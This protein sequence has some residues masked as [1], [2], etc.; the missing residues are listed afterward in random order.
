MV[1]VGDGDGVADVLLAPLA[2]RTGILLLPGPTV[3]GVLNTKM[4]VEIGR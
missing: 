4:E 3:G 1:V 2:G